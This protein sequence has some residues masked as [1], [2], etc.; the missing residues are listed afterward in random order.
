MINVYM[1]SPYHD[2]DL[3]AA[4]S[5]LAMLL[6]EDF[7]SRVLEFLAG[8][9]SFPFIKNEELMCIMFLYGKERKVPDG[10]AGEAAVFAERTATQLSTEIEKLKSASSDGRPHNTR[11]DSEFIRSNIVK[12]QLQIAVDSRDP[13]SSSSSSSSSSERIS[14]DP[15][16]IMDLF[17]AHISY[18]N[19]DYYFELYGPLKENELTADIRAKLVGR[20]VM[21]GYNRKNERGIGLEHPMVPVYLWFKA[22]AGA[23]P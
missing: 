3:I 9:I 15:A 11:F 12:R 2:I 21:V 6:P 4:D 16:V 18:Y 1:L 10:D 7:G 19:Q 17:A 5:G 22:Q 20:M 13:S 14:R 23:K 8:R